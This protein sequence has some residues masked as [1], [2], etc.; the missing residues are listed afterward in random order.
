[1]VDFLL[2]AQFLK[3][4]VIHWWCKWSQFGK[5]AKLWWVTN[6]HHSCRLWRVLWTP[7]IWNECRWSRSW[8]LR[9]TPLK[10][11]QITRN[12]DELVFL[13]LVANPTVVL[14]LHHYFTLQVRFY[15]THTV[16]T[17][18]DRTVWYVLSVKLRNH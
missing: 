7:R 13:P 10:L 5:A 12:P 3:S 9:R 16:Y 17:L 8:P 18:L 1:V 14:L 6:R 2:K 11:E 15:T 4:K